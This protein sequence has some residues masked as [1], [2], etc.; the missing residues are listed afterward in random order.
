[1]TRLY[2]RLLLQA[3]ISGTTMLRFVIQ[4]DGSVDL[5]SITVV[6]TSNEDFANASKAAVETFRFQP[7]MFRGE[8]VRTLIQMPINWQADS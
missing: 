1:M 3:G 6:S 8:A 5:A 7:G 2:P 4:P